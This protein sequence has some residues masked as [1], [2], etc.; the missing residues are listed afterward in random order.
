MTE[1]DH[2]L[3][4]RG[5]AEEARL[6]HQSAALSAESDAQFEKIGIMPGERVVDLGCGPGD[7][8]GLLSKRVGPTGLVLGI[9]RD[10]HFASLARRYAAGHALSQMEVRTG[11][12]Y[13]TGLPRASFDGAH[14]RL[15]LVNVPEPERIV[16]EMV[17]LVRPGGWVASF[18]ADLLSLICDPPSPEW[19]RLLDV[20]KAYSA[21]QGVDLCIGR[22][23]HRLF[24]AAGV[25]D[26]RVDA[27]VRVYPPGDQGRMI[28]AD[29][30]NNVCEK[31]IA[32]G[33]IGRMDLQKDMAALERH[34]SDPEVLVTSHMFFLLS[35][36]VP[37]AG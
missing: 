36:R 12:V 28:L 2:Y 18:E 29:F 19:S 22:R 32:E 24:R 16:R 34:L 37:Q 4:G 8:L 15:V 5:G 20:Y 13:D 17:S 25:E 14:M 9:E 35:G 30:I 23:T 6:E 11:D 27:I 26:I 33:F 10:A 31:L 21:A 7:V 3:L 1:P